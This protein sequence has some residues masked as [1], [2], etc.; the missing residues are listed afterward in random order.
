MQR[1][2]FIGGLLGLIGLAGRGKVE[3]PPERVVVPTPKPKSPVLSFEKGGTIEWRSTSPPIT[4][5]NL[6]GGRIVTVDCSYGGTP[7][8]IEAYGIDGYGRRHRI[9]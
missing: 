2:T 4:T 8:T 6:T 1:R 9:T 7:A 5:L 3:T